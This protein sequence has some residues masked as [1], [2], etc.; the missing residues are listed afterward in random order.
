M[1]FIQVLLARKGI[2]AS[3]NIC[4]LLAL[5]ASGIRKASRSSLCVPCGH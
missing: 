5:S 1:I 2:H 4:A 3:T